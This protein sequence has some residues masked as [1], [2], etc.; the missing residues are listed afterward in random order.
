MGVG[1][2]SLRQEGPGWRGIRSARL[3]PA[4]GLG[5]CQVD[6]VEISPTDLKAI[7]RIEGGID[8]ACLGGIGD[9]GEGRCPHRM[10]N[11]RLSGGVLTGRCQ[12]N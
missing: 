12:A 10:R 11:E 7:Q 3:A 5:A 2:D 8:V 9:S 6:E 4:S 1:G